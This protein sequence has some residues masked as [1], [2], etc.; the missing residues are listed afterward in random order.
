MLV[1]EVGM[2]SVAV[3][4]FCES[5]IVSHAPSP[6]AQAAG[7]GRLALEQEPAVDVDDDLR[8]THEVG[9]ESAS[10]RASVVCASAV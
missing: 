10:A 6:T 3:R 2:E 5:S 4:A 8:R 7:G 1:T 9:V